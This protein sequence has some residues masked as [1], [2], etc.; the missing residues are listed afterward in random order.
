LELI[1]A[2]D[3]SDTKKKSRYV[4]RQRGRQ[5][6]FLPLGRMSAICFVVSFFLYISEYLICVMPKGA[7]MWETPYD[8]AEVSNLTQCTVDRLK[9]STDGKMVRTTELRNFLVGF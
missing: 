7:N 4:P 6:R 2:D 5:F 9:G 1:I 8:V 3:D